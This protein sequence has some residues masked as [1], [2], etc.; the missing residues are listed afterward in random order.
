MISARCDLGPPSRILDPEALPFSWLER[1]AESPVDFVACDTDRAA[2]TVSHHSTRK[3]VIRKWLFGIGIF[4]ALSVAAWEVG[5]PWTTSWYLVDVQG[6]EI[7]IVGAYTDSERLLFVDVD[8]SSEVV[9]ITVWK[10]RRLRGGI[11]PE[12][13]EGR[14]VELDQP[15]GDRYLVGCGWVDCRRRNSGVDPSDLDFPKRPPA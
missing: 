8:E 4:I 9:E 13:L 2:R 14:V 5:V 12:I 6:D 15:L 10:H 3:P 11:Q 1:V 7:L